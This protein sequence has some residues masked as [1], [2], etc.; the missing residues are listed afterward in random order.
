M[1]PTTLQILLLSNYEYILYK[2]R[3]GRLILNLT[4]ER[5]F[6]VYDHSFTPPFAEEQGLESI[7]KEILILLAEYK[8]NQEDFSTKYNKI[9]IASNE[10]K[11]ATEAWFKK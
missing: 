8:S 11:Q 5:G 3:D 2:H 7:K 10:A 6:G 4:I 1:E 9:D